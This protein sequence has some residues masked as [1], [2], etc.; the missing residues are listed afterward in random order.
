MKDKAEIEFYTVQ[1]TAEYL[2]LSVRQVYRLLEK[3]K[4][5]SNKFGR[6][7]R[8]AWC[9]IQDYVA[10]TLKKTTR[11]T[12]GTEPDLRSESDNLKED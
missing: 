12:G 8:I 10:A 11:E 4:L 7:T 3:G 6:A 9:S 2:R 1:E 5:V